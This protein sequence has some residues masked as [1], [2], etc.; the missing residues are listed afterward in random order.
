MADDDLTTTTTIET[1]AIETPG[2]PPPAVEPPE[3]VPTPE[4]EK[5]PHPLEPGGP[6]FDEV[7]GRMKRAESD[8]VEMRERLARLEGQ[9]E[10]AKPAAPAP[11]FY[12]AVQLQAMVDAG[13]IQRVQMDEQLTWQAKELA[14]REM[15]QEWTVEQRQMTAQKTVETYLEKLPA[16][17]DQTSE[18]FRRVARAAREIAEEFGADVRDARVQRLALQRSFG[19]L[20]RLTRVEKNRDYQRDRADLHVEQGGGGGGRE[21]SKDPLKDVPPAQMAYWTKLGYSRDQMLKEAPYVLQRLAS[22][23]TR[24]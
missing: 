18:E 3:S 13:Q 22:R 8:V 7:Y 6:R 10:G 5:K 4:A 12:S 20:D 11:Q 16:L 1:P 24:R 15:R 21:P 19:D 23:G 9:R 17:H 2:A 14:K